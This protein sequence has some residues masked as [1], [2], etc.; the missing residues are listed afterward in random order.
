MA[1]GKRR[2]DRAY[3]GELTRLRHRLLLMAGRVEEMVTH[4]VTAM[5]DR[6]EM[7]A[8]RTIEMDGRVNLDEVEIDEL[9]LVILAKRQPMASDL[10]FLT[11]ALKMVVDL[12]RIADLAVNI[13]ER[14]IDL[15]EAMERPAPLVD[16]QQ[17]AHVVLSM[18]HD[19]VGA[20]VD[21]DDDKA[22]AVID[23]DDVVDATYDR[24]FREILDAML[25]DRARVHHGV[26]VLSVI[27][28][29]ERM[30]DH[31][32]NLAEQ[33]I[34]MVQGKDIRHEGKLDVR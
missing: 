17:M 3:E 33:V 8:R 4:A 30:A 7:L 13:S 12:E 32:T 26:H 1:T 2:T 20:F 19:A 24:L 28:Y 10:R 27:K 14:A 23:R 5:V 29:L 15:A 9:C 31:T 21:H 34:F 25:E 22:R 11:L 16:L 6:D 18:I